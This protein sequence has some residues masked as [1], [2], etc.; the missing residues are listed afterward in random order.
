MF[1]CSFFRFYLFYGCTMLST[2][3]LLSS[4]NLSDVFFLSS[5]PTPF[6]DTS[7][8]TIVHPLE[9]EAQSLLISGFYT[10]FEYEHP[11]SFPLEQEI[12]SFALEERKKNIE[13]KQAAPAQ[14]G[15]LHNAIQT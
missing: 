9:I 2:Q 14:V 8:V 5:E 11:N 1:K 13:R 15:Y 4:D 6:F 10:S 7:N 3:T 12:I